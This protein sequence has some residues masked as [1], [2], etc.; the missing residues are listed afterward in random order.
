MVRSE[1]DNDK[2]T[3][4]PKPARR[5]YSMG[6][7]PNTDE[8]FL[9]WCGYQ[10]QKRGALEM[11][12]LYVNQLNV[13]AHMLYE[14]QNKE[15]KE[16]IIAATNATDELP[17]AEL[18]EANM[19]IPTPQ[20]IS[21]PNSQNIPQPQS[22]EQST[23]LIPEHPSQNSPILSP[24]SSLPPTATRAERV[25][26]EQRSEQIL[27]ANHLTMNQCVELFEQLQSR[28][29]AEVAHDRGTAC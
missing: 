26:E 20:I 29:A 4:P 16:L 11:M 13:E 10:T 23:P 22:Q 12:R 5:M 8:K 14:R 9:E 18:P 15:Q 2:G 6:S 1:T 7:I 21:S 28:R 19:N 27:N 24:P 3:A 17:A 25:L